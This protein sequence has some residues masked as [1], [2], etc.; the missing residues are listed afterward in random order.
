MT[1]NRGYKHLLAGFVAAILGVIL[2]ANWTVPQAAAQRPSASSPA[3]PIVTRLATS[4]DSKKKKSGDVV[5]LRT[6]AAVRLPDETTV[7]SGAKIFGHVTE[8][9]AKSKGDTESSLGIAFDKIEVS[10]GK[11]VAI[12]G[13]I[14]AVGPNASEQRSN[15]VDYGNSMNQATQHTVGG[16]DVPP[17]LLITEH[18]LGVMGLKNLS[19]SSNG[20]L[21]SDENAVKLGSDAQVLIVAK[22]A[23]N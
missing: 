12:E 15:G 3:V 2:C 11:T 19:L 14:H 21:H 6:T 8:A 22:M 20:T 17:V 18:S 4:L 10:R 16:S 13:V 9:K 7:P 1:I 23:A 5:E